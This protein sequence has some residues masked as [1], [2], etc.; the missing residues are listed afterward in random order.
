MLDAIDSTTLDYIAIHTNGI[1]LKPYLSGGFQPKL[2]QLNLN[3]IKIAL[4]PPL[5]E[6]KAI[7][8]KVEKLLAVYDQLESQIT[9]NQT[10]PTPNN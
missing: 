1:D 10:Q 7:V 8:A 9:N 6:Q 3:K 4:P 2:S 5:P